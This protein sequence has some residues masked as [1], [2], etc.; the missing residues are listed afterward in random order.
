MTWWKK[1]DQAMKAIIFVDLAE[2]NEIK[3]IGFTVDNIVK[4][5]VIFKN[6]HIHRNQK[7]KK[8]IQIFN[9]KFRYLKL[10]K[11]KRDFDISKKH[12]FTRKIC[13]D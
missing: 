8:K 13:D 6:I 5:V 7:I 12:F 2:N 1:D 9:K 10:I 11:K 3:I 4:Y